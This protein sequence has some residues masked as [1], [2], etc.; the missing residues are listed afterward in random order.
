MSKAIVFLSGG[1]DSTT[2]LAIAKSQGYACYALTFDYGQRHH[3]EIEYARKIAQQLQVIEHRIFKIDIDQ[4]KGSAL[5]DSSLSVPQER[6]DAVPTTYVP[7]RNTIFLS[8]ALAWAEVLG[9]QDIF[10]GANVE[11]KLNYPDCR[12][13]YINAFEKMA[14]LA[15]RAGIEGQ[16][17]QIHAPLLALNKGQIIQKGMDLGIDYTQTFSCYDPT[18][19]GKHCGQCDA[20]Y[21]RKKGFDAVKGGG[22]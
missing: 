6:S 5:T 18:P 15:T 13:D 3:I 7:A 20:C 2:C 21:L 11:D 12:P 8:L 17:L 19:E 14:N 4:W 16:H 9:V 10:F 22:A 1:I